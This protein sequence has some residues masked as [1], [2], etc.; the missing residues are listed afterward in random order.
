[1]A[2]QARRPA[3][4]LSREAVVQ[5]LAENGLLTRAE[6]ARRIGVS[7]A[8]VSM[9]VTRLIGDGLVVESTEAAARDQSVLGVPLTLNPLAGGAVGV[10]FAHQSLRVVIADLAHKVLAEDSREL[11]LDHDAREAM[12]LAAALVGELLGRSGLQPS[13]VLGVGVGV[14]GAV[15]HRSGRPTPSSISPSWVGLDVAG[16]FSERVGMPVLVD[17]NANLGA[18]AEVV[19]GAAR[20]FTDVIYVKVGPGVG[21]GI[22]LGGQLWRGATGMSGELG[23]MTVD[24]TG[25]MCRCGNRGCLEVYV[26][27]WAQLGALR[28][29]LGG[30]LDQAELLALAQGGD[31]RCRRVLADV[32][33][34][35]GKALANVCNIINPEAIVLGGEFAPAFDLVSGPVREAINTFA[36]HL[37]ATSVE[38]VP[39][40]LGE[41]AEALGGVALVFHEGVGL[42]T[43]ADRA[44]RAAAK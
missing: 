40:Q 3:L 12:D 36:L 43:P 44:V 38:V 42:A 6:L 37:A 25:P 32:G 5:L 41:R 33:T 8:A 2:Y 31:R 13:G 39:S 17:N 22:V 27:L 20:D 21:G 34:T 19:W 28:P 30:R 4:R 10:D 26:G 18:L 29:V 23:H 15:D 7:R 35:L 24:E 16:E 11:A 14:P 1:V 9:T